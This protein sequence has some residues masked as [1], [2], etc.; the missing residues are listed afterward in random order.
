[1]GSR[2]FGLVNVSGRSLVPSPPARIKAFNRR[3]P[4]ES[5]ARCP[6]EGQADYRDPSRDDANTD[7]PQDR[8]AFV[9]HEARQQDYKDVG[10]ADERIRERQRNSRQDDEPERRRDPEQQEPEPE[11]RLAGDPADGPGGVGDLRSAD[12]PHPGHRR[13]QSQLAGNGEAHAYHEKGYGNGCPRT[14]WGGNT[15][16]FDAGYFQSHRPSVMVPPPS[17]AIDLQ[18]TRVRERDGP[19]LEL[20]G[21]AGCAGEGA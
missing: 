2:C 21:A 13:L 19:V 15:Q 14:R 20:R 18:P 9:E 12:P 5:G 11:P 7:P 1:M 17:A 8:D 4:R 10:D 3:V 6:P 16:G